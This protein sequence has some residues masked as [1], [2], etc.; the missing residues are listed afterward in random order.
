MNKNKVKILSLSGGGIRG[1]LSALVIAD[2]EKRSPFLDKVD[3]LA[4]TSTGAIIAAYIASGLMKSPDDMVRFY[5]EEGPKIFRRNA[6]QSVLSVFGLYSSR[7][8]SDYLRKVLKKYFG[9]MTLGDLK[10]RVLIP[11]MDLGGNGRPYQAK[12]FDNFKD[13]TTDL[14]LT[15][16]DVLLASTAAPTYF[17]SHKIKFKNEA[18]GERQYVDGGLACNHPALSSVCSACDP[19]GFS[20]DIRDVYCLHIATGYYPEDAL[21]W[22]K[23]GV[24]GWVRDAIDLA[25]EQYST[26][27]YQADKLLGDR[28]RCVGT[29][30]REKISLDDAEAIQKIDRHFPNMSAQLSVSADYLTRKWQA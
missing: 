2:L 11:A 18:I 29:T 27:Q 6:K 25:T 15:V 24:I 23:R 3:L 26:V 5:R 7:Y 28:F 19:L 30:F 9:E 10:K 20:A 21:G 1:Y 14:D 22:K 4:G 12:F 17:D 8:D 16:V 13:N